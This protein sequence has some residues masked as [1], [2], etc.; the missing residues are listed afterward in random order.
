MNHLPIEKK[1][2]AFPFSVDIFY[3]KLGITENEKSRSEGIKLE[4]YLYTPFSD[5]SYPIFYQSKAAYL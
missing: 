2:L 3:Q 5:R 4:P 1:S